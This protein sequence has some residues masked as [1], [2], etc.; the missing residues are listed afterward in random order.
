MLYY[1]YVAQYLPLLYKEPPLAVLYVGM[2]I[3]I[4]PWDLLATE[5][6]GAI[7][8]NSAGAETIPM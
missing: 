1:A 7:K 3:G 6:G 5:R 2:Y 4:R 8:A